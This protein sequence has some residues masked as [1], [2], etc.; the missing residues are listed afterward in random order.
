[1]E[2]PI[3][4]SLSAPLSGVLGPISTEAAVCVVTSTLLGEKE[5]SAGESERFCCQVLCPLSHENWVCIQ[6]LTQEKFFHMF[7]P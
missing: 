5:N 6:R 2:L 4:E 3:K 7:V 1:M